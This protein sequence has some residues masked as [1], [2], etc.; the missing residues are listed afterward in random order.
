MEEKIMVKRSDKMKVF[1]LVSCMAVSS[2]LACGSVS[3]AGS[4]DAKVLQAMGDA[5]EKKIAEQ[6]KEFKKEDALQQDAKDAYEEL[7]DVVEDRAAVEKNYGGAYIDD[8]NK[9]VVNLTTSSEQVQKLVQDGTK[10]QEVEIQKK[11][12]TYEELKEVSDQ[13]G[14]AIIGTKY[15]EVMSMICVNAMKNVVE[16][17]MRDLSYEK[18]FREE[19]CNHPCIRFEKM[20]LEPSKTN[21]KPGGYIGYREGQYLHDYS[22]GWRGWRINNAGNYTEGLVT[23]GHGNRVGLEAITSGENS[24]GKFVKRRFGGN[25]DTTFVQRTSDSFG[26]SNTIKFSGSSLKAGYYI[27]ANLCPG[28][29]VYKV[30]MTTGLTA[31]KIIDPS[32]KVSYSEYDG[33]PATAFTDYVNAD[34]YSNRG[35]SGGLVYM[36]VNGAYVIAGISVCKGNN[37][38]PTNPNSSFVKA[39]NIVNQMEIYPY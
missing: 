10:S 5:S 4:S 9:L 31:G 7:M 36:D 28:Q 17:K 37:S 16:V 39:S 24:F 21:L 34:Y 1:M 38:T 23:A 27:N 11:K 6:V 25:L 19:I 32:C 12:Y 13:I 15:M 8:D 18:D 30:G 20:D 29:K 33:G 35:D 2:V 14:D 22:I 26:V 3:G